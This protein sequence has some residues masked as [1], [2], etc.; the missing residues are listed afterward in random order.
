ML[1]SYWGLLGLLFMMSF[2]IWHLL[3]EEKFLAENLPVY[4]EYQNQ[5]QHRLV[6]YVW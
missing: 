1:G 4:T 2:L 5:V 6:P 3:D